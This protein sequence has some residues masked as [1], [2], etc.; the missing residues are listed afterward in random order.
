MID[1]KGRCQGRP[2]TCGAKAVKANLL[3]SQAM[4]G[5]QNARKRLKTLE[6]ETLDAE[7]PE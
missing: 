7:I 6:E 3:R 5:N 1:H 2:C 4:M